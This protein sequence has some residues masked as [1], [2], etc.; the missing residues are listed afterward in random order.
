[1]EEDIIASEGDSVSNG[2]FFPVNSHTDSKVIRCNNR[3]KTGS[4]SKVGKNVWRSIVRLRVVS[5][6]E[7]SDCINMVEDLEKRN[8]LAEESKKEL[9]PKSP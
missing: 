5:G 6:M 3:I 9:L 8:K 4:N 2:M 7:E 1:M